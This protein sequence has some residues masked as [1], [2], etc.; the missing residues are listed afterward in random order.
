MAKKI[1]RLT[2]NDLTKLVKRVI[3]EQNLERDFVTAI[4][5]FLIS[6]KITGDDRQPLKLDGRTDN[7][8]KSQTA[9]AI[10][11]YQAAIGCRRNDGVW[12]EETWSK[13]P[14][15]DRQQ[16]EDLVAEEGGPIDQFINWIGKKIRG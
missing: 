10:S 7:N 9:Q 4:Q 8:L 11:K 12:G 14:P 5:R 3:S 6:K 16:L 13:M 1:I 15:Q 2:E